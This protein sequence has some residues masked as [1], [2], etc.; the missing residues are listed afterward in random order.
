MISADLVM[1]FFFWPMFVLE[2]LPVTRNW[3]LEKRAHWGV[4]VACSLY[5]GI[6]IAVIWGIIA[7]MV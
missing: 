6:I 1:L 3:R 7:L 2:E 4:A 5:L